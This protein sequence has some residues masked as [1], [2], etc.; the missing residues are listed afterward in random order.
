MINRLY[1][2]KDSILK[3]INEHNEFELAKCFNSNNFNQTI[4]YFVDIFSKFNSVDLVLQGKNT[5]IISLSKQIKSF[6]NKITLWINHININNYSSFPNLNV[7][8]GS[9][10]VKTLILSHLNKI[11]SS[12]KYY[13]PED[14]S[15]YS[16]LITSPFDFGP[17]LLPTRLQETYWDFATDIKLPILFEKVSLEKFWV[18]SAINYLEISK[19]SQ[20]SLYHKKKFPENFVTQ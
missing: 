18:R 14:L 13:F 11:S 17:M 12:L 19:Y 2:L 15:L 9:I 5:N 20:L 16:F 4:A 3:F 6:R 10:H 8:N 1:N 7:Y